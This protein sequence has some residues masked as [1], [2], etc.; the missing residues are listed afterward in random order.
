MVAT[1]V[2]SIRHL[3]IINDKKMIVFDVDMVSLPQWSDDFIAV[4]HRRVLPPIIV[5]VNSAGV[6]DPARETNR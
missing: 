5:P 4:V 6:G 1:V 2:P 3:G